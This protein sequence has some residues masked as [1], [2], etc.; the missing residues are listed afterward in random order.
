MSLQETKTYKVELTLSTEQGELP[1]DEIVERMI[2]DQMDGQL[3]DETGLRCIDVSLVGTAS[4][5]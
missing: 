1:I 4:E 5:D 2:V 3:D